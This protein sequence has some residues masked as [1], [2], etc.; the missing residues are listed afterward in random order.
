M[1]VVM[2]L[3]I[4][5]VM[6]GCF[7][8]CWDKTVEVCVY[9]RCTDSSFKHAWVCFQDSFVSYL[10]NIKFPVLSEIKSEL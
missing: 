10:P 8:A 4:L 9:C 6:C 3:L 1:H 7:R 5:T 2:N